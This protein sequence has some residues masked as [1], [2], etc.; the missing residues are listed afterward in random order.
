MSRRKIERCPGCRKKIYDSDDYID[1]IE[2]VVDWAKAKHDET[3]RDDYPEPRE[4]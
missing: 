4:P 2:C 3:D 1:H